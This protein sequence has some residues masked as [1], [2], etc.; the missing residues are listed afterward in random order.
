MSNS[1][2]TLWERYIRSNPYA[3]DIK[4]LDTVA[5]YEKIGKLLEEKESS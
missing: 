3:K 1:I 2:K 5:V 4:F